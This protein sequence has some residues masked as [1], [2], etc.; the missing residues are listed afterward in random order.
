MK[1]GL[2]LPMFTADVARPL[3]AAARAA[4]PGYD[5]VFA[6]DHL[7]PPG[8]PGR[9]AL[10]PFA[11][12]RRGRGAPS[13][14]WASGR[15]SPGR[16]SGRPGL[17]AKQA[18]GAGPDDRRPRRSSA[19]GPATRTARP[20][21]E[22]F[23]ICSPPFAERVA[24]LE[25]TVRG[26]PRAV[27]GESRGPAGLTSPRSP[28]APSAR[29]SPSSG[30]GASDEVI[31]RGGPVRRRVERLGAG[32]GEVRGGRRRAPPA[33]RTAAGSP[34]WGGIALVGTRRARPGTAR[35]ERAAKGLS[36][37]VWQG[38][39]AD[40]RRFAI[41]WG[42]WAAPGWSCSPWAATDRDRGRAEALCAR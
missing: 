36:M 14:S 2:G 26:A 1:L 5:G 31:A 35:D 3:A 23:G 19:S 37:D 4:A 24:L 39:R 9:P 41:G 34:T 12:P 29:R 42:R 20:E 21:H 25:E 6:P 38:D 13:R 30:S 17:L 28:A 33:R 7:F 27:R 8:R 10:E 18:R 32:C 40:L 16:R 22:A 11:R 15:W